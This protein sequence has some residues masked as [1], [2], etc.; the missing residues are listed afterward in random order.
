MQRAER[1]RLDRVPTRGE[2]WTGIVL[3]ALLA[4]VFLP[5]ASLVYWSLL[6][7]PRD[8]LGFVVLATILV[9]I[10]ITGV[11]FF[12]RFIFTQPRAASAHAHQI[13]AKVAVVVATI[14]VFGSVILSASNA[15]KAMSLSLLFAALTAVFSTRHHDGRAKRRHADDGAL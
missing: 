2:R 7:T 3:S 5:A 14:L 1:N 9:L 10:G 12:Y 6:H 4:V 11:F 13:Y 15:Q 8:R